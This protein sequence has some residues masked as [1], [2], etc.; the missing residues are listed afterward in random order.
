M[1]RYAT[2]HALVSSTPQP[3]DRPVA[4]IEHAGDYDALGYETYMPERPT[5]RRALPP[6][7]PEIV[8]LTS[9]P[10]QQVYAIAPQDQ[11]Q[12][13]SRPEAH[14]HRVMYQEQLPVHGAPAPVQYRVQGARPDAPARLPPQLLP[15]LAH[16]AAAPTQYYYERR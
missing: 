1:H 15:T 2:T 13:Y 3:Y 14:A 7:G 6:P 12:V 10:R 16:G 5:H 9:P 4:S 8:D 11:I